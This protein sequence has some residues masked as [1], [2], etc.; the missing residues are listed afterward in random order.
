MRCSN[1]CHHRQCPCCLRYASLALSYWLCLSRQSNAPCSTPSSWKASRV[2]CGHSVAQWW[3][4]RLSFD[5]SELIAINCNPDQQRIRSYSVI[6]RPMLQS[7]KSP[8][9]TLLAWTLWFES[10][11]HAHHE[12]SQRSPREIL[13]RHWC[14][15]YPDPP[16]TA[17]Q[18][19]FN[20][21]D[22]T[23]RHYSVQYLLS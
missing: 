20:L 23:V 8:W 21:P 12:T 9:R 17:E 6:R 19:Y 4:S 13:S 10:A 3:L 22:W 1:A 15:S 7:Y 18:L 11:S 16:T 2:P 14:V 5:H